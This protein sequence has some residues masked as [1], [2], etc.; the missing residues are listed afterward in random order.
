MLGIVWLT[1]KTSIY[2]SARIVQSPVAAKEASS[3]CGHCVISKRMSRR[4]RRR[5]WFM[6]DRRCAAASSPSRARSAGFAFVF[7]EDSRCQRCGSWRPLQPWQHVLLECDAA[8][9]FNDPS[10]LQLM[11]GSALASPT[12]ALQM[13]SLFARECI[14]KSCY[15]R[16][17]QGKH[18]ALAAVAGQSRIRTQADVFLHAVCSGSPPHR[19]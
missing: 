3:G 14:K 19:V 2:A 18:D 11:E 6:A 15:R 16:L 10:M 5:I 4:T 13:T 12:A 7:Q 1:H 9:F 17:W 8:V